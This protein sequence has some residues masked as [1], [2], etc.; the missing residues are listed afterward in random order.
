MP[1]SVSGLKTIRPEALRQSKRA[2]SCRAQ[3]G[4][5]DAV[6]MG[7][8]QGGLLQAPGVRGRA[9]PALFRDGERSPPGS[10]ARVA[11]M[12][13]SA[14]ILPFSQGLGIPVKSSDG[15]RNQRDLDHPGAMAGVVHQ[16]TQ[17]SDRPK[18]PVVNGIGLLKELFGEVPHPRRWGRLKLIHRAFPAEEARQ[19]RSTGGWLAPRL[20]GPI[21]A[22]PELPILDEG[23]AGSIRPALAHPGPRRCCLDR[24]ALRA[25]RG[26]GPGL[27]IAGQPRSSAWPDAAPHLDP[28]ASGR[29]VANCMTAISGSLPASEIMRSGRRSERAGPETPQEP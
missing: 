13:T 23:E 4:P 24:R 17:P 8:D 26:P 14:F 6:M 18:Q 25:G 2:W 29:A 21:P 10:R 9:G 7:L 28:S 15:S 19:H 20:P 12:D 22:G 27:S 16:L 1:S 11:E 5:S 3:T